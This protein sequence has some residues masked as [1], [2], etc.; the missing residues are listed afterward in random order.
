MHLCPE[1]HLPDLRAAASLAER[2]LGQEERRG[3]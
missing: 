1:L 3:P 2:D